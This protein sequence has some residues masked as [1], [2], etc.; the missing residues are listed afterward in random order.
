[1][2]YNFYLNKGIRVGFFCLIFLLCVK[3]KYD[4]PQK[5]LMFYKIEY[6]SRI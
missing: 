5:L 4:Y 3:I 2:S 6:F 1:M